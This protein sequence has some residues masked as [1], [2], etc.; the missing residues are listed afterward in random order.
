[1]RR[2]LSNEI[3]DD[4]EGEEEEEKVNNSNE[5]TNRSNLF[6]ITIKNSQ[7]GDDAVSSSITVGD[8]ETRNTVGGDDG[9][10]EEEESVGDAANLFFAKKLFRK[11]IDISSLL[12]GF[13]ID[14]Q[15]S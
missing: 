6:G 3:G 5:A 4:R 12:T 9:G 1:M 8:A 15:G 14:R 10:E 13:K 2:Y 7:V 11:A